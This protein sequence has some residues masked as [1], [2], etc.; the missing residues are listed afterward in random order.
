MIITKN[1]PVSVCEDEEYS[2]FGAKKSNF[3]Q[4][5][6]NDVILELTKLVESK[7]KLELKDTHCGA[8]MHDGWTKSGVHYVGLC[9]TYMRKLRTIKHGKVVMESVPELTLVSCSPMSGVESKIK[10]ELKDTQC[11]A[12]M[13][14]G[15]TKSGAHYIGLYAMYMRKLRRIKYGKPVIVSVPE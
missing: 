7:I 4:Y 10:Q 2:L 13:H 6:I 3:S 15:W 9:A 8:I 12:I 5:R 14:D 1:L 11:G